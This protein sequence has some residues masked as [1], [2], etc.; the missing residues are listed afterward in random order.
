MEK[1]AGCVVA[2]QASSGQWPSVVGQWILW[3]LRNWFPSAHFAGQRLLRR[4]KTNAQACSPSSH[5]IP[6]LRERN[7]GA[8]RSGYGSRPTQR[9]LKGAIK[10]NFSDSRCL[11]EWAFSCAYAR[12]LYYRR[13]VLC[14]R[15]KLQEALINSRCFPG[16]ITH[17]SQLQT[18]FLH[19]VLLITPHH[20]L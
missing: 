6:S 20:G 13:R 11:A 17:L 9:P 2:A 8:Q 15:G 16:L 7:R 3:Y 4:D 18:N 5:Y 14:A 1:E 19:F 12:A 10:P